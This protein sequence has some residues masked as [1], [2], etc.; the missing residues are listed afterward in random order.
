M[1]TP[2]VLNVLRTEVTSM[3]VG[4]TFTLDGIVDRHPELGDLGEFGHAVSASLK[5]INDMHVDFMVYDTVLS[6]GRPAKNEDGLI[7]YRRLR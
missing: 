6:N 5:D 3:D 1:L 7:I 4:Q 2:Q